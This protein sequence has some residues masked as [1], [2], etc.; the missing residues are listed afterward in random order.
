MLRDAALLKLLEENLR[1]QR[2]LLGGTDAAPDSMD[3]EPDVHASAG[4]PCPT[5]PEALTQG[6]KAQACRSVV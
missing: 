1:T 2:A 5:R 3:A 4:R 6:V